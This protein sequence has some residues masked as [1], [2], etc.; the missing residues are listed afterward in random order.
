[1]HQAALAQ[2]ERF[3][4]EWDKYMRG[5]LRVKKDSEVTAEDR[6]Q[7][8]LILFGDPGSNRLIADAMAKLPFEWTPDSLKLG[9]QRLDPG[10]HLPMLIQSSPFQDGRYVV[11]NSGHTFHE[12][13]FKGTNA[14]LYP[15]LGD[16]AVVKP[17]PTVRDPA[18]FEVVTAGLFDEKW[19]VPKK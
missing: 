14:L 18:A 11:L 19:Q 4:R 1:M 9:G 17:T 12:A 3:R 16:Y 6:H 5:Q 13:D 10:T 2:F 15:R 8:H 7:S